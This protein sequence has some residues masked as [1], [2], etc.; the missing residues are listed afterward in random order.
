MISVWAGLFIMQ[1]A[2]DGFVR[3]GFETISCRS[4][5]VIKTALS[6]LFGKRLLDLICNPLM[7]QQPLK[8]TR[9]A[10]LAQFSP[11]VSQCPGLHLRLCSGCMP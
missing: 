1:V 7:L 4:A 6:H 10:L 8:L 11:F 2:I 9:G 5:D 3:M